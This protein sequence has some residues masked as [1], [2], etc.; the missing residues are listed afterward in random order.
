MRKKVVVACRLASC[1]VVAFPIFPARTHLPI[2]SAP[3]VPLLVSYLL[4]VVICICPRLPLPCPLPAGPN[5]LALPPAWS[6]YLLTAHWL[7]RVRGVRSHWRGR[8]MLT[9]INV[10]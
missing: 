9:K 1:C 5:P 6:A 4:R 8:D 3:R 2:L 10:R 7:A